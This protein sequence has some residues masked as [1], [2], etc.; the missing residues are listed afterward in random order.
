MLQVMDAAIGVWG[1]GRV[2]LHLSPCDDMHD[3]SDTDPLA[4]YGY[5]AS[6]A[7]HREIAFI[8]AREPRSKTWLGP[9]LKKLFGGIYIANELFTQE[10]GEEVLSAGE[11]D[12]VAY[13]QLFIANPDLPRRFLESSPLN[14][15]DSSTFYGKGPHG[16]TDYPSLNPDND[17]TE[18]ALEKGRDNDHSKSL[19]AEKEIDR[20]SCL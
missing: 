17:G 19:S 1:K 7:R 20:L 13:G 9:E 2:G 11:A 6:E 4:T 10:S 3:V 18:L 12:A 16:Y 5:V 14:L 8:C 15:P